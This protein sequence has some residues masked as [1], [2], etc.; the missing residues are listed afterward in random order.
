MAAAV[1]RAE[2]RSCAGSVSRA[3]G[4]AVSW[5]GLTRAGAGKR[6]GGSR[7]RPLYA[8][9]AGSG[10]V[11]RAPPPAPARAPPPGAWTDTLA[12]PPLRRASLQRRRYSAAPTLG[13]WSASALPASA[14]AGADATAPRLAFGRGAA[15]DG[16][17]DEGDAAAST[18]AARARVAARASRAA[19]ATAA[20]AAKAAANAL[21]ELRLLRERRAARA[22]AAA[23]AAVR[24]LVEGAE[25]AAG[26]A[27][28]AAAE[29][30]ASAAS[31]AA[32]E[33]AAAADFEV[34][35]DAEAEAAPAADGRPKRPRA[36]DGLSV[37]SRPRRAHAPSRRQSAAL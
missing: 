16:A 28:A 23:A 25:G 13:P 19:A 15:R 3:A 6:L 37:Q 35:S 24:T 2:R 36:R 30:E 26:E 12:T 20:A 14:P 17:G 27:A 18:A 29:A 5:L 31:E 34:E 7:V 22:L 21:G 1:G 9:D 10:G 4:V 32:A 8:D 33:A 11:A